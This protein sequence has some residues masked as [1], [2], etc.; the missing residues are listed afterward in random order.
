MNTMA[1]RN[2]VGPRFALPY[3]LALLRAVALAD[4]VRMHVLVIPPQ[5]GIQVSGKSEQLASEPIHGS[6]GSP[7]T[8]SGGSTLLPVRAELRRAILSQSHLAEIQSHCCAFGAAAPSR[9]S[10]AVVPR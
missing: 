3:I 5:A 9:L 10:D 4:T 8:G 7:R 6:T 2:G 1:G